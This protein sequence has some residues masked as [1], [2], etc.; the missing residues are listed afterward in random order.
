VEREGGLFMKTFKEWN[1]NL[2]YE[3]KVVKVML[4]ELVNRKNKLEKMEKAKMQ[5]SLF[6]MACTAIFL[7]LGYNALSSQQVGMNTNILT[8]LFG[9][10]IIL[11]LLLLLS[12][13]FVQLN[14]FVKKTTK[15]EKE[16]DELREEIISRSTE[17]WE[18]DV[19][20]ESRE[21]VYSFM[22]KEHDIN[23]YHK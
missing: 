17:L 10:P 3:P 19:S 7:L 22:K 21:A 2:S 16:F 5:W 4:E 15:A 8:A 13:G 23:L 12:V 20:W 9:Q 11:F 18:S 1:V 6:A 14:F